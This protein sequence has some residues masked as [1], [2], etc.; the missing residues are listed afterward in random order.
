M[1]REA[2]VPD[3]PAPVEAPDLEDH[4]GIGYVRYLRR[5]LEDRATHHHRDDLFDR[6]VGGRNGIDDAT[7]AHDRH[8]V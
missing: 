7:I 2:H 3:R 5:G 8:A 4:L 1:D 6:G